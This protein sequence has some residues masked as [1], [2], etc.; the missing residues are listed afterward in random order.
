MLL[1]AGCDTLTNLI[2]NTVNDVTNGIPDVNINN[3]IDN[4]VNNVIEDVANSQIKKGLDKTVQEAKDKI[5]DSYDITDFNYA[6]IFGDNSALF[7]T[8][9]NYKNLGNF[10]VY[11]LDPTAPPLVNARSYNSAG[12][13]LY[14]TGQYEAAEK[15]FIK[16]IESYSDLNMLDSTEGIQA[17]NNLGLLYLSMGKFT[18]SEY[19]LQ[20]ALIHRQN[21]PNDTTGYAASL[22]NLGVLYK[23]QG[24]F[25]EAEKYLNQSLEFVKEKMGEDNLQFAMILNNI[26]MLYQ[27]INKTEKAEELMQ[28][29][30]FIAKKHSKEK[31]S[32]YIRLNVN[33][34]LLYQATGKYNEAEQIYLEAIDTKKKQLGTKHPDYAQLLRN[35]AAL[36]ME[37]ERYNQVEPLLSEAQIIYREKFG[38]ENPLFAKTTFELGAYYYAIGDYDRAKGLFEQALEI[39]Q[40]VL[41]E[42]HPDLTKTYE[43]LG[44]NYWQANDSEKAKTYYN[45]AL[46]NYIFVVNTYFESMNDAEKTMFWNQIQPVF[47]RYYNFI[48]EKN[49]EIPEATAD[50]Y[51]YH[52]QTKALLLNSSRKVKDRILSSNNQ[53]LINKYTQWQDLMNYIAKLYTLSNEELVERKINLDSLIDVSSSMEKELSALSSE[54]KTSSEQKTITYT[55][56]NNSLSENEASVEIIRVEKFNKLKKTDEIFYI[57]LIAKKEFQSPKIVVLNE[58]S[59]M[60]NEY[61]EEYQTAIMNG[62]NME[63]FYDYYWKGIDEIIGTTP[64][65]YLS[66]DGIYNQVNINTIFLPNGKYVIDEKKLY[67][68]T[69]TKDVVALKTRL[70]KPENLSSKTAVMIGFPDY[71]LDLPADYSMIPPLPGTK[72]EV[73]NIISILNKKSWKIKTYMGKDATES[74]LKEI[75]NPYVLHIATHGYFLEKSSYEDVDYGR[76]FG[77]EPTRA[78]ENPLLRSGLLLAGADKT[79]LELNVQDNDEFDDGILN[80]FEAMTMNLDKTKLVV[81]SACQTGLGEIKTGEGVYGLQRA[82]QIAGAQNIITSLWEVSDEGTQDLMSAFY[83]YWLESG[84]EF[85]AFR[86][87]QLDIKG[88]YKYPYF[89]GAFVLI[90]K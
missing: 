56:V 3:N 83:R 89:W 34:A 59:K 25:N 14:I 70:N 45:K 28:K 42:H 12:E 30:I 21:N 19:N 75:N 6:V 4:Q 64:N 5:I 69:N 72:K 52:I 71:L 22:N 41:D 62:K 35:L 79:I 58:G 84:N 46:D 67:F 50:I 55:D 85:E 27:M 8:K 47:I 20:Q 26:A 81:L 15:S 78:L 33:L 53:D 1:V 68:V 76:S 17:F 57:A 16:A 43:Y 32:T 10:S 36:Y 82:F 29:S 80:A 38:I 88:K 63:V 44:L 65:I 77:V 66:V 61:S 11:V 90:G 23:N 37:M 54:F 2:N 9:E 48:A 24:R 7:E 87:A 31:S 18:L 40:K 51:S 73:E 86:K 74:I 39:Q 60:E 49:L 13:I